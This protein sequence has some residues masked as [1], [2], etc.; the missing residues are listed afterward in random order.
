MI[1]NLGYTVTFGSL[2]HTILARGLPE[3]GDPV[4]GGPL[5]R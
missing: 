3:A 1:A 4:Y 2:D 5:A